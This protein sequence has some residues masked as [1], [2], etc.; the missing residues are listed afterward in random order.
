MLMEDMQGEFRSGPFDPKQ[1]K[2]GT[3]VAAKYSVRFF[4]TNSQFILLTILLRIMPYSTLL[5]FFGSKASAHL[6]FQPDQI[7]LFK[8]KSDPSPFTK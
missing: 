4:I 1:W 8:K 2:K 5:F 7:E 3:P 6:R